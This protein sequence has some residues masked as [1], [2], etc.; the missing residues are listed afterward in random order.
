MQRGHHAL[1]VRRSPKERRPLEHFWV[2]S[3]HFHTSVSR[4][5]EGYIIKFHRIWTWG[6]APSSNPTS[7]CYASLQSSRS[8]EIYTEFTPHTTRKPETAAP[9]FGRTSPVA[10]VWALTRVMLAHGLQLVLWLHGL[11]PC[12]TH[13]CRRRCCVNGVAWQGPTF[14][15]ETTRRAPV[16]VL[17]A[18]PERRRG[19]V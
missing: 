9:L 14:T 3:T 19:T 5:L 17:R 18:H 10:P 7:F 2:K 12:R 11:S 4:Y 16:T 6:G 8:S 13:P 1:A 15:S